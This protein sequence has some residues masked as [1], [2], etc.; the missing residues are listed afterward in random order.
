MKS[1][2]LAEVADPGALEAALGLLLPGQSHPWLLLS[3]AGDPIAYFNVEC[4]EHVLVD[5]SGRHY[6]EDQAVLRVLEALQTRVGG[7]IHD[8]QYPKPWAA[9]KYPGQRADLL[10]YLKSAEN[11]RLFTDVPEL[12]FL[13]H[14]IFDDHDFRPASTQR[15][16]T[17]LTDAE[18]RSIEIFVSA[19]D[20]AIGPRTKKLSEV[21]ASD[22][23]P[24]SEAARL[25]RADLLQQGEPWLEPWLTPKA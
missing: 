21:S 24:V 5:I 22:W 23:R 1:Y 18:E 14:F 13:V 6:N 9:L 8:D 7:T 11:P 10:E 12:E 4:G 17:L 16:L 25:A 2:F 19:L 20:R 15:G 3:E